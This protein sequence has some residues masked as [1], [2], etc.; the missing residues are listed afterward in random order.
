MVAP[1][2]A[3]QFHQHCFSIR[4]D[5]AVDD[6]TGGVHNVVSEVD[7]VLLPPGPDNPAGNAWIARETALES[8]LQ[9]ARVADPMV[10][11]HWKISNPNT[12]HPV[13]KK[14]TAW[15]LVTGG[16]PLLLATPDS[17]LTARGTFA[18][19]SLW[20]TPHADDERWP[21]GDYTIQ[22]EGG[23]GLAAWTAA[24]RPCGAG[25]DP[26]IWL[27]LGTAHVV[28]PEQFPVMCVEEV[29]FHLKPA[30]FFDGNPA[31]DL[32]AEVNAASVLEGTAPCCA[33]G[34]QANGVH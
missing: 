34:A 28:T 12:L 14:P 30:G 4:L 31:V 20:V 16:F 5:P 9:A 25:A 1:G 17:L 18:T 2:V 10:G 32:P 15:K 27:T 3:A 13:T 6:A 22:S 29:G 11:R 19:K 33:G 24:D 8:E 21:A 23:E 7:T 26:V